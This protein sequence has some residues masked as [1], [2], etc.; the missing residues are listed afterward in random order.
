MAS[1]NTS[2]T[3]ILTTTLYARSKTL[4]DNVMENTAFLKWLKKGDRRRPFSGGAA[5]VEHLAYAESTN[6]AW[7]SGYETVPVA[8][9]ELFT[10]AEF[11]IKQAACPVTI[12]GLE[13]IQN[14]EPERMLDLMESRIENAE[15]T[16]MNKIS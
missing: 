16:M 9:Q 1:P 2:W 6:F 4:A 8:A 10:S 3:D 7:Y 5:I 12:S 15:T 14:R 13:M 11:A